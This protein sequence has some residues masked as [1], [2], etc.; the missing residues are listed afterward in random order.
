MN[1]AYLI[2]VGRIKTAFWRDAAEHY[3]LRLSKGWALKE[4]V[5][6]DADSAL[7][8]TERQQQEGE[9]ILAALPAGCAVIC[10]DEHGQSY[11]SVAFAGFLNTLWD[12][13][14]P[15]CFIIGGAYGLAENVLQ[16]A[17]KKISFGP[18]TLPHEL[19]C[20]VLWEQLFRAD[21]I[22]RKTGYH[23]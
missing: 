9:R 20:V 14:M 2:T 3:R 22:L 15:P 7:P 16:R 12:K 6:K 13:A 4:T 19:A 17:H 21:C 18:M 23:H 8:V 11:S 5:V 10:L 1:K